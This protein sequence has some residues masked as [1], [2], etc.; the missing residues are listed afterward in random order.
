MSVY[1]E[2][3]WLNAYNTRAHQTV[4][5]STLRTLPLVRTPADFAIH[6]WIEHSGTQHVCLES[7]CVNE[8]K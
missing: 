3:H 2:Y 4:W 7:L 5:W 1:S 8:I 6:A